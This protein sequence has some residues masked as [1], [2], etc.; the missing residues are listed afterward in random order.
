MIPSFLNQ[1][2][3]FLSCENFYPYLLLT[4]GWMEQ[5]HEKQLM[6]KL[7]K[8]DHHHLDRNLDHLLNLHY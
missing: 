3:L 8:D 6:L 2:V 1:L 7:K 5:F 4:Y